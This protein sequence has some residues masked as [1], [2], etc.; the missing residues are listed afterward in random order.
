MIDNAIVNKSADLVCAFNIS[1]EVI[2][3]HFEFVS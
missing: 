3:R 2:K 1:T